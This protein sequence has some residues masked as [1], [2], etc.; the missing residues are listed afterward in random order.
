MQILESAPQTTLTGKIGN[1]RWRI[2]AL[3]FFATT[4]NYIDRNV[5]SFVMA[6]DG[7]RREMLGLAANTPLTD[8]D[9]SA[10][11]A[12]YGRVDAVFKF[13]Y[14]LGFI[15]MGWFIDKIGVRKGYAVAIF[16]WVG[17]A[18]SHSFATTF[19][20]LRLF[21][22][23]L[24]IGEAGNFPS[25]IKTV[26]EWFPIKER[27]KA[28]GIFNSGANIGIIFTAALVPVII[29]S[30]GWQATFLV[31]SSLGFVLL[32]C[33][34]LV[35]RRPEEHPK[36]GKAELAYIKSDGEDETG[37]VKINWFKLLSYRQTWAFAL[38]KFLTDM[39]WWFYL[40][41]L[42]DFFKQAGTFQLDLKQLSLPFIVIYIVSD[43]GSILFGWLS[44]KLISMGWTQN[45][46]RKLTMLICALC[47]LPVFFASITESLPVAV[48]LIAVA[49]AAHQGWSANL[50]STATDMF[51]KK[52][53]SS[54][55]GIGGYL[56]PL[57][58]PYSPTMLEPSPAPMDIYPYS[59]LPPRLTCWHWPLFNF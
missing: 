23:T 45:A 51:P 17:S 19:G 15:L 8:A 11:L 5:L 46:A 21:R 43:A 16:L 20:R 40:S 14:G 29:T 44:S 55:I 7:F 42:P 3:L 10:F 38:G 56:E 47:V 24:G 32:I 22:F 59:S 26:A 4:I 12:E 33:W 30:Y 48:A 34:L 50:F 49:A 25:A 39:V 28:V 31:T 41:F 57:A 54:V 58:V 53:V 36:L 13:A 35:Y 2:V 1:F 6:D 18:L 37:T 27:S 9:H 52:V